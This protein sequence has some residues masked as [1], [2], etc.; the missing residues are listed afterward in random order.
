MR[1]VTGQS[2]APLANL[3][4]VGLL[5]PSDWAPGE[6][7]PSWSAAKQTRV[8]EAIWGYSSSIE[9]LLQAPSTSSEES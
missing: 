5:Q 2:W 9:A 6:M 3:Q 1:P 4:L 7:R 8:T